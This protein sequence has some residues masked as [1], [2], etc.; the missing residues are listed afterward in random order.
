MKKLPFYL[1]LL[2]VQL[3][4]AKT[5]KVSSEQEFKAILPKLVPK[6]VVII[7]DGTYSNWDLE[8]SAR[9]SERKRITIKAATPGKVIFSGQTDHALFKISGAY[10]T[11]TGILFKECTLSKANGKSGALIE[12][13]DSEYCTI[14]D[15][16]FVKN[17]ANAQFMPLVIVSGKGLANKIELCAFQSNIDNQD[18]QVKITKESCPQQTLIIH[19]LFQLKNK[20][21]WANGNGGEC[22]QVG[23][24]P[25]LLGN[26]EANTMVKQNTFNGCNGE[27]EV[28]SNKSSKNSYINNHFFNNDGELVMR[29]GHDCT[30]TY[31][32]FEG[33]TGGIRINGTGHII[34]NNKINGIQ[35]AIRL[36]YGMA[37]GKDEIGFYIAASGCTIKNNQIKDANTGILIG[38]N[39]DEDWTGKFDT[40]RYPSPVMQSVAPFDNQISDNGFL[41]V[42][43]TV[44]NND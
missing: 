35:T 4:T 29:G 6:D 40:K 19:N 8:I 14:Y 38:D 28:I 1:L 33:G 30:I 17:K 15:C 23:Q 34:T 22:V 26:I 43:T 3:A 9:G 7:A 21:S 13:K 41:N 5:Y 36:M 37:K 11:L 12:L 32:L 39:K 27:S 16:S 42:R 2:L 20:V 25:V 31:N 24:D 44:R 18:L 10:I